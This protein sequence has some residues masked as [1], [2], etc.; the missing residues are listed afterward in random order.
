M[1]YVKWLPLDN[2]LYKNRTFFDFPKKSSASLDQVMS[3][4]EGFLTWNKN[5]CSDP[6]D[7]DA[8][9]K[10]FMMYQGLSHENIPENIWNEAKDDI[11]TTEKYFYRVHIIW[12]YLR[13]KFPILSFEVL[14]ILTYQNISFDSGFEKKHH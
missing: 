10:E 5:L 3:I 4:A 12:G 11:S 13:E 2:V 7:F 9:E 14:C 6:Q 1:Y 8:C